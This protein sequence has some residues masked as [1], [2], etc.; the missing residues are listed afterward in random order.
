[1]RLITLI[2][3]AQFIASA[4]AAEFLCGSAPCKEASTQ[5]T[6]WPEDTAGGVPVQTQPGL[7]ITVPTGFDA[8]RLHERMVTYVYPPEEGKDKQLYLFTITIN[9]GERGGPEGGWETLYRFERDG[10]VA[11]YFR[12]PTGSN[13][14]VGLIRNVAREQNDPFGRIT[15]LQFGG[16]GFSE[17]EFLQILGSVKTEPD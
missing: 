8:M 14:H 6:K 12:D 13:R 17:T 5:A 15:Y 1:M 3:L 4:S 16:E 7:S 2:F 10:L 9:K 11:Y